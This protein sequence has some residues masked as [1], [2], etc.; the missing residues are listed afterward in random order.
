MHF[1]NQSGVLTLFILLLAY[2]ESGHPQL[3]G[4]L[5]DFKHCSLVH[6]MYLQYF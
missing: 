6:Y 2:G 4:M 3:L 5:P 1:D